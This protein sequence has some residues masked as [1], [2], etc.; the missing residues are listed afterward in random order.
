MGKAQ[1]THIMGIKIDVIRQKYDDLK[2][3]SGAKESAE[4]MAAVLKIKPN[5][6]MKRKLGRLMTSFGMQKKRD[7]A[8]REIQNMNDSVSFNIYF[9]ILLLLLYWN[10]FSYST[11]FLCVFVYLVNSGKYREATVMVQ[12]P[13][14]QMNPSRAKRRKDRRNKETADE[15]NG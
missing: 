1:P 7:L 10:I 11:D 5:K 9:F 2:F 14:R 12:P 13:K 6:L 8:L 3:D 15:R 4:K